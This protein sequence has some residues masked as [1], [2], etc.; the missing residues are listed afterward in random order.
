[1]CANSPVH[2]RQVAHLKIINLD[3]NLISHTNL[4]HDNTTVYEWRYG[5]APLR[6]EEPVLVTE[7]EV[8]TPS[9][10]EAV[11]VFIFSFFVFEM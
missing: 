4:E 7:Q 9:S 3:V 2:Y 8:S 10:E 6:I 11:R 5:E 1:M